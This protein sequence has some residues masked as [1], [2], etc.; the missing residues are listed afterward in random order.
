MPQTA[1]G[2]QVVFNGCQLRSNINAIGKARYYNGLIGRKAFHQ[3]AHKCLA[4][5]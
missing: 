3:L 4:I 2:D 1:V 5:G